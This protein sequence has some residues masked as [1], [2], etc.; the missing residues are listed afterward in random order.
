MVISSE[1][2]IESVLNASNLGIGVQQIKL[3]LN[4]GNLTR[5]QIG[6]NKIVW[7]FWNKC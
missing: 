3:D 4:K 5:M 1:Y 7:Q 2:L 6:W